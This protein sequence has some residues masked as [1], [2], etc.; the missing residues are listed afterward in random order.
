MVLIGCSLED[1]QSPKRL[2]TSKQN[3]KNLVE[4]QMSLSQHLISKSITSM[5]IWISFFLDVSIIYF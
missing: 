4:I 3:V 2:E 5:T 1:Y